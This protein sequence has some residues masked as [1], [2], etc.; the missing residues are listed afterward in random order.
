MRF[1]GNFPSLHS[2]LFLCQSLNDLDIVLRFSENRSIK[3]IK[4]SFEQSI[5]VKKHSIYI[6]RHAFAALYK[7][8]IIWNSAHRHIAFEDIITIHYNILALKK[9]FTLVKVKGLQRDLVRNSV[10][11]TAFIMNDRFKYP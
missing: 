4:F 6:L 8:P 9:P 1:P 10:V 2:G 3:V 7:V 11:Q 5:L